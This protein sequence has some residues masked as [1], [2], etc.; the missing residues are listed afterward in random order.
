MPE[1]EKIRL[2]DYLDDG[3]AR[4]L[5]IPLY[6]R[7]TPGRLNPGGDYDPWAVRILERIDADLAAIER[8]ATE[9]ARLAC[10]A[11]DFTLDRAVRDFVREHPAGAIVNLGFGLSTASRRGDL[12]ACAWYELDL[13][14]VIR[15]RRALFP[16]EKGPEP[17]A[18]SLLDPSWMAE[19]DRDAAAGTLLL[20]AGVFQYFHEEE[21][22]PMVARMAERFPGGTLLF[23]ATSKRGLRWANRFVRGAGIKNAAMHFA[24][25]R[26]ADLARWS[27]RL[28]ITEEPYF[29][30]IPRS[31]IPLLTRLTLLAAEQISGGFGLAKTIRIRFA[32]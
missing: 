28:D 32:D 7:A 26:A 1:A 5:L 11:R 12:A 2:N 27:E 30:D 4:T 9:Y 6:S 17:I 16:P 22:M 24:V 15:L 29:Q 20:A 10:L 8:S 14:E 31:G 19:I 18:Q 23:E 3:V 21:L 13:P 25:D